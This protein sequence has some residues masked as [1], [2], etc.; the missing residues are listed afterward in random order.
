MS[1]VLDELEEKPGTLRKWGEV[2]ANW[3]RGGWL[4]RTPDAVSHLC[5]MCFWARPF[6]SPDPLLS[7]EGCLT[8]PRRVEVNMQCDKRGILRC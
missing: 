3:A 2:A 5:A 7:H 1:A 4:L 6:I 8:T